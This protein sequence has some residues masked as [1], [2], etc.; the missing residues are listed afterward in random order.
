MLS[1]Q[2]PVSYFETFYH[3]STRT[4]N[5]LDCA[6]LNHLPPR[7]AYYLYF[8]QGFCFHR[9]CL[10]VCLSVSK[11]IQTLQVYFHEI[12]GTGRL[13]IREELIKYWHNSLRRSTRNGHGVERDE[14]S[15]QR[16]KTTEK[17]RR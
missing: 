15:S 5:T 14:N 1:I 13:W 11:I 2:G 10:F 12:W 16:S 6:V 7:C 17:S 8:W 4:S 3:L 9:D